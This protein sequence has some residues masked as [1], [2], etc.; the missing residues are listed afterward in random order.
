MA[1]TSIEQASSFQL[2]MVLPPLLQAGRQRSTSFRS[3]HLCFDDLDTREERRKFD[4]FAAFRE[5]FE[6]LNK[7]FGQAL[8]PTDYISL[9]ETLYPMRTQVSFKQYNPDKP[10]KYGL[11]FKSLN[12]AW[13]P[14]TYQS[15]VYSGKPDVVEPGHHYVTGTIN[16]IEA[17][18]ESLDEYQSLVGRNISMDRLYTS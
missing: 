12:S 3:T 6:D 9:D 1:S 13:Y 17:L 2:S 14:Y 18:F 10:A 8:V 7:K 4:R 15:I 5:V 11:L 16:Y